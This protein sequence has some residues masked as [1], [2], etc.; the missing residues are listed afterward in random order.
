MRILVLAPQPFFVQ[1]GTP[2]AVRLLLETLAKRGDELDVVVFP[3]GED[4][5]IPGCHF[6]RVP[7]PGSGP[8]GPGFSAKKLFLDAILAPYAAWRMARKR[9]DLVI[10]VEE[11]A[12]IALPLRWIFGVPYIFD[13]DS[14]CLLY[15]SPS[16]RDLSTS[17]MPSSA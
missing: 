14:S 3:G 12:F 11:A 5:E 17:R 15:T 6:F 7:A 8:I 9:Y 13:V 10:A 16:P 1:R 2:I 4:V